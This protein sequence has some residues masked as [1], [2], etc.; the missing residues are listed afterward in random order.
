VISD[1]GY[2]VAVVGA[3]SLLGKELITVLRERKFPI[4]QLVRIDTET[5]EPEI[6]ILDLEGGTG[7]ISPQEDMNQ[8]EPDLAFLAAHARSEDT[9]PAFMRQENGRCVVVD[10]RDEAVATRARMAREPQGWSLS[11]PF[12]DREFSIPG[13]PLESRRI[14]SAHPPTIV[15]GGVLL[16]LSTQLSIEGAVAQVFAPVSEIGAKA[17]EELQ[18]Q[19]VNLLS[20]HKIP[21]AVFGGQLAFN[22]LPRL[23]RSRRGNTQSYRDE[24]IDLE[25]RVRSQLEVY[26]AGRLPMPA[27]RLVQAPVFYSLA[28]SLYVET[29]SPVTPEVVAQTLAGGRVRVAK[30]SDQAPSQVLVTGS[31]EVVVDAITADGG[32]PNG[33]WIWA[34][35]DNIRL[36]TVNAVEIAE[37]VTGA[38]AA[39]PDGV[40]SSA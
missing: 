40:P 8:S 25:S 20:F 21:E 31:S 3:S 5:E 39:R 30:F 35:A 4:S 12:L 18:S 1:R 11:A 27:L 38:V 17:I 2:Q 22:V 33:I 37:R 14:V 19:I 15:Q 34:T 24:L 23:G 36:A 6:P 13:A 28:V 29:A 26:L 9:L 16:R 7:D 10:L 32:H